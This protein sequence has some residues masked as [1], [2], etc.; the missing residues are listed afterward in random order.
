MVKLDQSQA[1]MKLQ[2]AKRKG[3][4]L[5]SKELSAGNQNSLKKSLETNSEN[6]QVLLDDQSR[7]ETKENQND[8]E[9]MDEDEDDD[10]KF[11]LCAERYLIG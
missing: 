2:S 5:A 9:E 11:V 8:S 1:S 7:E 3:V 6:P 4:S 10:L